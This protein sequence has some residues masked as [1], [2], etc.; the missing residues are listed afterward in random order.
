VYEEYIIADNSP[1]TLLH[2]RS[3]QPQTSS[4]TRSQ[5]GIPGANTKVV[6]DQ[7]GM[8]LKGPFTRSPLQPSQGGHT[9]EI[10]LASSQ[11]TMHGGLI[12]PPMPEGEEYD[13]ETE[14]ERQAAWEEYHRLQGVVGMYDERGSGDGQ[15]TGYPQVEE[16]VD[17]QT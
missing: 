9:A 1:G 13:A 14:A 12:V 3:E 4:D 2:S 6:D 17:T 11:I 5:R 8:P 7:Y 10:S 15:E 16:W